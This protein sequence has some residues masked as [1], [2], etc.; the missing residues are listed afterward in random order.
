[1][2]KRQAGA[3]YSC[4]EKEERDFHRHLLTSAVVKASLLVFL[5]K[6]ALGVYSALRRLFHKK[7]N[8]LITFCN[9]F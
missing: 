4:L 3:S 9:V 1:M 6:C 8:L 7:E 5:G 2:S